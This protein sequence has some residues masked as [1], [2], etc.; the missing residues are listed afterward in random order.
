MALDTPDAETRAA[1]EAAAIRAVMD[2]ERAF[3]HEPRAVPAGNRGCDIESRER[4]MG[5]LRFIEVEGR[6]VRRPSRATNCWRRSLPEPPVF[7]PWSR[8]SPAAPPAR[9]T[10]P[11]PLFG[12]E[13]GFAEAAC[14]ISTEAIR[15]AVEAVEIEP[16]DH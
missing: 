3:D 1:V 11:T 9:S 6:R 16:A 15:R 14:A 12:P 7:R 5:R 4:G 10:P 13:P 8:F 2:R